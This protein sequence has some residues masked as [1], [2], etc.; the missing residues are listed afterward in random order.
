[1][2]NFKDV[3]NS[4]EKNMRELG[5]EGFVLAL[6]NPDGDDMYWN[7]GSDILWQLG[8]ANMLVHRHNDLC[9]VIHTESEDAEEGDDWKKK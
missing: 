9:D 2:K 8:V 6:R 3:I 1:M 7:R 4:F 5:V